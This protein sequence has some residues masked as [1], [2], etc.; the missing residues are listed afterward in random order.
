MVYN[1]G[2][3]VMDY[4]LWLWIMVMDNVALLLSLFLLVCSLV[5]TALIFIYL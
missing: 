5:V 3:M 4:G 2:L 1:Y